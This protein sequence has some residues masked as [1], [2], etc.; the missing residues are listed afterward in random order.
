MTK[1]D[2]DRIGS[3]MSGAMALMQEQMKNLPPEQRERMEALMRGR[4]MAGA[5]R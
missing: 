4:G 3:Q 1:A 5:W 2:V